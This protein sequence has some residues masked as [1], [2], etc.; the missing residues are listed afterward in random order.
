MTAASWENVVTAG[1]IIGIIGLALRVA[2]TRYLVISADGQITVDEVIDTGH[3]LMET[4]AAT[5]EEIDE[6]L[7]TDE[8]KALITK[9]NEI[10]DGGK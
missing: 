1:A 6:V 3:A 8:G 4:I 2:Y 7:N 5:K 9:L 10:R